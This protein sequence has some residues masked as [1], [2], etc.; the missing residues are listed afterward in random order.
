MPEGVDDEEVDDAAS[1]VSGLTTASKPASLHPSM[2]GTVMSAACSESTIGAGDNTEYWDFQH[3]SV[4]AK[5]LGHT[6]RECRRPFTSIGDPLTER[7]GART[8]SR[9][10]AECFSGY[11]DP[12]SQAGSSH[13]AG[14]LAGTQLE[15]APRAKTTKMRTGTHFT[16]G[17]AKRG[18][19]GMGG[20]FGTNMGMGSLGFGAKSSKEAAPTQPSPVPGGLT[21][22]ELQQHNEALLDRSTEGGQDRHKAMDRFLADSSGPDGL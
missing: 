21:A 17:G 4:T 13:N 20:K 8:S 12:R 11:A 9:Y 10:H 16:G 1:M 7:R 2:A 14:K 19:G 6:C 15:A 18:E 5:D 22:A 3:R